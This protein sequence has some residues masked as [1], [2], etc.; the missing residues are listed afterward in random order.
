M[1][2][3]LCGLGRR[4]HRFVGPAVKSVL[5]HLLAGKPGFVIRMIPGGWNPAVLFFLLTVR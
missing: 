5:L 1:Y 4:V 3:F 2:D